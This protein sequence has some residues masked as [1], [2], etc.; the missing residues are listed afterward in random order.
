MKLPFNIPR[1]D[2]FE[3]LLTCVILIITVLGFYYANTIYRMAQEMVYEPSVIVGVLLF[4]ML[5][6]MLLNAVL[7]YA[8]IKEKRGDTE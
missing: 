7:L 3:K 2:T 6:V 8:M 5:E 4:I 1:Y